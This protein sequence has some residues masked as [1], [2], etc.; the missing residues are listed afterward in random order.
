LPEYQNKKFQCV[1]K[2]GLD[3]GKL[4][5]EQDKEQKQKFSEEFKDLIEAIQKELGERV[6]EV[7][8]TMRLT[9]SPACIVADQNDMTPQ[10]ERILRSAGQIVPTAKPILEVNPK[11]AMVKAMSNLKVKD[12]KKFTDLSSLLLDQAILAEGG[13]LNDPASFVKKFNQLLLEVV[14]LEA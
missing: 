13:Q 10:M 2:G 14:E 4:E 8:V 1:S 11:H 7:R 3:L 5:N 6:K 9:D 12:P